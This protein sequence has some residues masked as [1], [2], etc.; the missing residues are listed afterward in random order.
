MPR[1]F[2][3]WIVT[4]F[5][6]GAEVFRSFCWFSF[7]GS[8]AGSLTSTFI[9][10]FSF[11]GFDRRLK[12]RLRIIVHHKEV[13][14]ANLIMSCYCSLTVNSSGRRNLQ[15]HMQNIKHSDKY[16]IHHI[17]WNASYDV[18]SILYKNYH[19]TQLIVLFSTY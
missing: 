11:L 15:T 6:Y 12:L 4:R 18:Y 1:C 8:V 2:T 5:I 3:V 19:I 10:I 13:F 9:K 14:I 17:L 7:H 16:K